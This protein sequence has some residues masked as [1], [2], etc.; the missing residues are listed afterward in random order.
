MIAV[1]PRQTR[2]TNYSAPLSY[3]KNRDTMPMTSP[4]PD[5]H[6]V[7]AVRLQRAR[8]RLQVL[9]ALGG[10]M[11]SW[12]Y[13][14]DSSS[15]WLPLLR[16]WDG[17][18]DVC[19]TACFPMLPWS[20]RITAGGF[21]YRGQHYPLQ[22]NRSGEPYPIHGDGWQQEWQLTAHFETQTDTQLVMTLKSDQQH[23]NPYRYS[24]V[25]TL[26]LYEDGLAITL[27]ITNEGPQ[28]L[29]FGLG[30]H[31]YFLRNADTR[32]ELHTQGV[33]LCGDDP[34]PT[35]HSNSLP[36]GWDY[37]QPAAL[38]GTLIDNCFTGWDGR[39]CIAY[40][41][42][43]VAIEMQVLEPTTYCL[44]YRPPAQ[45]YFCLEPVTHPIDAFHLPNN[46]GLVDLAP[47]NS[48]QLTTRFTLSTF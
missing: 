18:D 6:T 20:N 34:I 28:S 40:H 46:P 45:D 21:H 3:Y 26:T 14:V 22:T 42:R 17:S 32:L 33:W 13:Q 5:G 44:L 4:K 47:G 36:E 35:T 43:G 2:P 10:S 7:A 12:E 27:Q 8:Q 41:D 15:E 39:A 30:L 11:A 38:N 23:G 9:P 1:A 25:Q 16:P 19:A 29:P 31:P 24:A 37:T 48:M